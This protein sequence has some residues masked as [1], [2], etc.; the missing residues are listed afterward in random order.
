MALLFLGQLLL[1]AA[2][3]APFGWIAWGPRLVIPMVP[4][5]L[6]AAVVLGAR[7]ATEP[8]GR[9]VRS[10]WLVPVALVIT[11]VGVVQAV[12]LDYGLAITKFFGPVL[13]GCG[14]ARITD[15]PTRYYDCLQRT[16]WSKRPFMLQLGWHGVNGA[17][18]SV[19]GIAFVSAVVTLL[20]LARTGDQ[21]VAYRDL[22]DS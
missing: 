11:A 9:F 6:V 1:L 15:H 12:A 7:W 20:A 19:A 5:M 2:W 21:T 16:A 17:L 14:D 4:T 8:I 3:W 10:V 13:P 22:T 18:G